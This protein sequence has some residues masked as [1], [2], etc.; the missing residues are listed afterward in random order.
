M[1]PRPLDQRHLLRIPHERHLRALDQRRVRFE[2]AHRRDGA[3]HPADQTLP[4]AAL[5]RALLRALLLRP[6]VQMPPADQVLVRLH[7][8]PAVDFRDDPLRLPRSLLP[9]A[10]RRRRLRRRLRRVRLGA[11]PPPE[12]VRDSLVL[13][14]LRGRVF[15]ALVVRHRLDLQRHLFELSQHSLRDLVPYRRHLVLVHRPRFLLLLHRVAVFILVLALALRGRV[16]AAAAVVAVAKASHLPSRQVRRL[17][18][19]ALLAQE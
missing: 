4:P 15:P 13:L 12:R 3:G 16:L 10:R 19:A 1:Q 14:L 18:P 7:L 5:L 17:R 6:H 8:P 9:A 11:F 2:R